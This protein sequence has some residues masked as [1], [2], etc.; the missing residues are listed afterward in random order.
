[1]FWLG[2]LSYWN[3]VICNFWFSYELVYVLGVYFFYN[4]EI[5]VKKKFFRKIGNIKKDF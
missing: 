5:V 1:M 4:Y 3:D 2:L